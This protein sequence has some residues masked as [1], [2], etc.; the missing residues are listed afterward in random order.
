M[1]PYIWQALAQDV[2]R[3]NL[4]FYNSGV[5]LIARHPVM[6]TTQGVV[7]LI[8]AIWSRA[9]QRETFTHT[10]SPNRGTPLHK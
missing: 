9:R 3:N 10:L 8:D 4:P 1:Y 6:D 7:L 5:H 2:T